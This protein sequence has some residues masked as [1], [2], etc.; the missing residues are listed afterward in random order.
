[1]ASPLK[2]NGS[3]VPR[4]TT[5]RHRPSMEL[6][7]VPSAS[8]REEFKQH[9]DGLSNRLP[10]P[11]LEGQR[12]GTVMNP[13]EKA[14]GYLYAGRKI[15]LPKSWGQH[16]ATYVQ[17]TVDSVWPMEQTS[18]A[19]L[20]ERA[21]RAEG[22][23]DV[24]ELRCAQE[25]NAITLRERITSLTNEIVADQLCLAALERAMEDAK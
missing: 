23:D 13:F 12:A 9:T 22:E 18:L 16:Y 14:R 11:S 8:I 3:S 1:M 2:S 25:K 5:V 21:M 15:G 10:L 4:R 20:Q 6:L 24:R 19:V 7:G 17:R